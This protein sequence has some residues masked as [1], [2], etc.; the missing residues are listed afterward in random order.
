MPPKST[1]KICKRQ[2]GQRCNLLEESPVVRWNKNQAFRSHQ[3]TLCL[4]KDRWSTKPYWRWS[5]VLE[6]LC[7]RDVLLQ[8]VQLYRQTP[9]KS[10]YRSDH[11]KVQTWTQSKTCGQHRRDVKYSKKT[12]KF[13]WFISMFS[14]RVGK[15]TSTVEYC[16]KLVEHYPNHSTV[17]MQV[18]I[19][20][21]ACTFMTCWV[22][23]WHQ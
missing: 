12:N 9:T 10:R 14:I 2:P 5:I 6:A 8:L 20:I 22:T 17:V 1:V 13:G 15:Y 23:K 19:D 16:T 11:L 4:A 18:N 3:S 21:I 7:C